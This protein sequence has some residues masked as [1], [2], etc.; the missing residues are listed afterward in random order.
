ME[1]KHTNILEN[2]FN[3]VSAI[4]NWRIFEGDL[5]TRCNV[6][7][8]AKSRGP[9]VKFSPVHISH[10]PEDLGFDSP[11]GPRNVFLT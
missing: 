7:H 4:I 5:R 11:W 2:I 10:K 1:E 6:E 8:Q 9:L 3:Y